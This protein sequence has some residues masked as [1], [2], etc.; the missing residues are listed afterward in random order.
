MI[1]WH[2][3]SCTCS[4]A[5]CCFVNSPTRV[6][7]DL[8]IPSMLSLVPLLL[9]ACC[10][11]AS[12]AA[13][14]N[15]T[16]TKALI[17]QLVKQHH[18]VARHS[19]PQASVVTWYTHTYTRAHTH[20]HAHTRAR[21]IRRKRK[22]KR[23]RKSRIFLQ[24]PGHS[25]GYAGCMASVSD[26]CVDFFDEFLNT[27]LNAALQVGVAGTCEELCGFVPN[28]YG[29]VFCDLV[30]L[31]VGLDE[32]ITFLQDADLDPVYLCSELMACP[33]DHCGTGAG[34]TQIT[35]VTVT[36]NSGKLRSTFTFNIKVKSLKSTG[37]GLTGVA[38][39]CP[40]CNQQ[41]QLFLATLNTGFAAGSTQ[42]VLI[43]LDTAEMDWDYPTGTPIS[44][45]AVSCRYDCGDASS[46][47]QNGVIWSQYNFTW[48][49]ITN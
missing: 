5:R 47:K 11:L 46:T 27:L 37:T 22:R 3:Y 10:A 6:N 13:E 15:A 30:C 34:C 32:F 38:I 1:C 43:S 28:S 40:M 18:G 19:A 42:S 26:A 7:F 49:P 2:W 14:R 48:G 24:K 4:A 8:N 25:Q 31:G 44:A 41:G 21:A 39:N 36:P 16:A 9:L 12:A 17:Y 35:G 29:Q 20:K 45:F 23:E 33:R